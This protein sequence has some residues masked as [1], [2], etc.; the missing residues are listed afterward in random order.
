MDKRKRRNASETHCQ[1]L[2]V[3][4]LDVLHTLFRQL[5]QLHAD[6][7]HDTPT[8]GHTLKLKKPMTIN[9]TTLTVQVKDS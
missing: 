8:I 3:N 9:K 1:F 4:N 7:Q 6:L 5:A 2:L